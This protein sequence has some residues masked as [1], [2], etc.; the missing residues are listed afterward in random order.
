[1]RAARRGQQDCQKRLGGCLARC[2]AVS[3]VLCK[4][5]LSQVCGYAVCK[6][7]QERSGCKDG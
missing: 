5:M 6:R 1:M 2:G 7:K 4:A 3:G